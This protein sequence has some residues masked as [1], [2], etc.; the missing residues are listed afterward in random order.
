MK[1]ESMITSLKD[2]CKYVIYGAD[3]YGEIALAGLRANG[4][5]P[6]YILDRKLAGKELLGAKILLPQKELLNPDYCYVVAVG[7]AYEE[8]CNL[9]K[10]NNCKNLMNLSPFFEMDLDYSKFSGKAKEFWFNKHLYKG[11]IHKPEPGEIYIPHVDFCTTEFCSLKCQH[12]SQLIPYYPSPRTIDLEYSLECFDR[13]LE[14]IDYITEV[15][16]LGGEPFCN[17]E[18]HKVVEHLHNHPKIGKTVIYTNGTIIPTKQM[19]KD[20]NDGMAM[21]HISYYGASTEKI[22]ALVK[23]LKEYPGIEYFVR[24]YDSWM[25][26]GDTAERAFSA[27]TLKEVYDSCNQRS[28]KHFHND[29]FYSCPRV[30][31]LYRMGLCGNERE[32]VDF[33]SADIKPEDYRQ[34]VK[35]LLTN[36]VPYEACLRCNGSL[37]AEPIPA[38]EQIK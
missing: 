19:L 5:E 20:L 18:I 11:L 25:D 8:V 14:T 6:E 4:V 29:R 21:V 27:A 26:L 33:A 1:V 10:D 12:C 36:K 3:A 16:V 24:S 17:V 22:A 34:C 28:C 23:V 35:E 37:Y 32:W 38:A 15:R 13:F 30:A 7:G 31:S 2:N 9:L